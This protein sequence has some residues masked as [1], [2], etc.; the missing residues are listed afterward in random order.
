MATK[1]SKASVMGLLGGLL[2]VFSITG[3]ASLIYSVMP[4]KI[5]SFTITGVEYDEAFSKAI[6]A[7]METGFRLSYGA[8]PD[9]SSGTFSVSRGSGFVETTDM[10]FFLEKGTQG[11]L[12]FIVRVKSGSIKGSGGVIDEFLAAYGKYVKIT[13]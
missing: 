5:K 11:K 8:S 13:P 9:K 6:R 12:S 10:N 3:C 2:I 4:T 7:A 1:I